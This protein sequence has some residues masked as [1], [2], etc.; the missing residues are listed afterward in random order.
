MLQQDQQTKSTPSIGELLKATD[1][2]PVPWISRTEEGH[3]K[4]THCKFRVT[5][6]AVAHWLGQNIEEHGEE[7]ALAI[8]ENA[9][10]M[11]EKHNFGSCTVRRGSVRRLDTGEWVMDLKVN[12]RYQRKLEA[13]LQDRDAEGNK[14][15]EPY[16][17]TRAETWITVYLNQVEPA[18]DDPL[19]APYLQTD[20]ETASTVRLN[21]QSAKIAAGRQKSQGSGK[22]RKNTTRVL[23][24]NVA[25]FLA[26]KKSS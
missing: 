16:M 12:K 21:K 15:G 23:P 2:F 10:E 4:M 18:A 6:E 13:W 20:N 11:P 22:A 26:S 25:A 8:A 3:F 5:A 19:S 14:V 1:K 7:K 24:P 9:T 17:G